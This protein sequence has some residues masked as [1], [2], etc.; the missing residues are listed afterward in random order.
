MA[1]ISSSNISFSG[2]KAAY[3]AGGGTGADS[4]SKL[5]DNKTNT[6]ISLSFFRNAALTDGN[7][8][9]GSGEISIN[10]DFK[11]KIF[12]SP[13]KTFV[14]ANFNFN[15]DFSGEGDR[16]YPVANASSSTRKTSSEHKFARLFHS[17]VSYDYPSILLCPQAGDPTIRT[18]DN[19]EV[20]IKMNIASPYHFQIGI[21]HKQ[22]QSTWEDVASTALRTRHTTYN[23]R[24]ALHTY[25]YVTHAG[26][27]IESSSK[28]D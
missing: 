13:S 7:N 11:G 15:D 4:D 1:E 26:H 27:D 6:S 5:R 2:L 20:W 25:G 18:E 16:L 19:A 28:T 22:G 9:P 14:T 10:D 21:I 17:N 23:D 24:I 12:G 8:I 3:V